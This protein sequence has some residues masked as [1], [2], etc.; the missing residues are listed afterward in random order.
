MDL[1][2]IALSHA[3][4][5]REGTNL[6]YMNVQEV[7]L[8]NGNVKTEQ[9]RPV[10]YWVNVTEQLDALGWDK[11]AHLSEDLSRVQIEL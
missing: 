5:L 6:R 3:I 1:D 7:I 8:S 10:S 4:A 9:E 11:A 2:L